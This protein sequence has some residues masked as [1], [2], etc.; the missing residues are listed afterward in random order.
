MAKIIKYLLGLPTLETVTP[1]GQEIR[2]TVSLP[3]HTCCLFIL[4]KDN[5]T[6]FWTLK[7][8]K[9]RI[10]CYPASCGRGLN[11]SGEQFQNDAVSVSGFTG[12]I[13]AEGRLA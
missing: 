4:G 10:F 3:V 7:L 11:L 9:N 6:R 5:S 13:L 2:A 1:H 8:I 12:F